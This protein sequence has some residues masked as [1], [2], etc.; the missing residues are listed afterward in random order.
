MKGTFAFLG[1]LCAAYAAPLF[2][3]EVPLILDETIQL[4][5]VPECWDVAKTGDGEYT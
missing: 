2:G 4:P 1:M 3:N 5:V